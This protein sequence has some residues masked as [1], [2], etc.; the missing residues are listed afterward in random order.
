MIVLDR[1]TYSNHGETPVLREISLAVGSG[2]H[3]AVMGPNGSGKS[4]LALLVKGLYLP[5][6]GTIT[7]DGFSAAADEHSRFEVMKRVGIVFQNPDDTII[8]TTVERELA[9]GLEN[10]GVPDAEMRERVNEALDRFDLSRH[11][12]TSP[13]HLSGG[14]RQRLALAA[15]MVMRPAYLILDEPTSLLDPSGADR[16]RSLIRDAAR[17]GATVI[18]ITQSAA[19]ALD[20]DRV[21]VL[22]DGAVAR[23]CP[24]CEALV[25]TADLGI[26]GIEEIRAFSAWPGEWTIPPQCGSEILLLD[27]ITQYYDRGSPFEHRALDSVS[28]SLPRGSSTVFLGVAGAGKTTLLEVAAGIVPPSI[29]R[30]VLRGECVRAMAFQFPEDQVFGDTVEEY[31]AFGPENIGFPHDE[32]TRAVREA[33][34]AVGLEPERYCARDPFMLSGGEKRLVALAGTL[35]MHPDVLLLDEPTAG[36]DRRGVDRIVAILRE[37]VTRGGT[38][39]FST[40]DFRAARLLARYA[41]VLDDGRIETAGVA[42]EVFDRSPWIGGIAAAMRPPSKQ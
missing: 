13:D 29:G 34:D 9:F 38:L 19:E 21:I 10:L 6:G 28:L 33:L 11:R 8:G 27:R 40:Q 3:V 5:T 24:P 7:V 35:S 15:V 30:V 14:E 4:T 25:D 18:H 16:I 2:S 26:E 23:D 41:L 39:L 22:M 42:R 32:T 37:Y 31:V 17:N 20:A 12:H 36:L 1:L